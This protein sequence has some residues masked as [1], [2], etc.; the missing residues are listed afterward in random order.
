MISFVYSLRFFFIQN[1]LFSAVT[2]RD[3][4]GYETSD[5]QYP[6]VNMYRQPEKGAVSSP[7]AHTEEDGNQFARGGNG[8]FGEPMVRRTF[9]FFFNIYGTYLFILN[10]SYFLM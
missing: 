10:V 5:G 3:F 7:P 2:D 4:G 8:I 1:L 9:K 6:S